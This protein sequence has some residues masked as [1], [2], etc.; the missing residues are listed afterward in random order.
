MVPHADG[1][2][3]VVDVDANNVEV[4][5]DDLRFV[6]SLPDVGVS[7]SGVDSDPVTVLIIGNLRLLLNHF[8]LTWAR[9]W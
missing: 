7:F 8:F 2:D 3:V 4:V 9:V 6:S 1:V 5:E